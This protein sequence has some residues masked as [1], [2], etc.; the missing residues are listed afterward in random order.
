MSLQNTNQS[1]E[2]ITCLVFHRLRYTEIAVRATPNPLFDVFR[3]FESLLLRHLLT[4]S[5][6]C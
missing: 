6:R 2:Q 1:K 3:R 4:R 5:V